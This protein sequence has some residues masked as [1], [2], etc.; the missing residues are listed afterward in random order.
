[1][2]LLCIVY[3]YDWNNMVV[4]KYKISIIL[5]LDQDFDSTFSDK[6]TISHLQ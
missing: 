3:K 4:Q 6:F 5:D 1:M 2:F